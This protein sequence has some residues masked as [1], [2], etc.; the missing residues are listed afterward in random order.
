MPRTV[1]INLPEPDL[2]GIVT[3]I[4]FGVALNTGQDKPL[5]VTTFS[6]KVE[7]KSLPVMV[8]TVSLAPEEGEIPEIVIAGSTSFSSL[9]HAESNIHM[10]MSQ[11]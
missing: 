7:L 3:L 5:S 1:T 9:L 4:S 6:C 11:S 2:A 10:V 8:T